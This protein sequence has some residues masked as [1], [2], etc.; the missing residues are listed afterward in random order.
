MG[1]NSLPLP[2][3]LLLPVEVFF[4]NTNLFDSTGGGGGTAGG[5]GGT[6]G[7]LTGASGWMVGGE[8]WVRMTAVVEW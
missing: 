3:L 4:F 1:N 2:P 8:A 5:G 6:G 7:A